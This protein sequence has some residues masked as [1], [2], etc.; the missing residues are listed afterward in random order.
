MGRPE[1]NMKLLHKFHVHIDQKK[2]NLRIYE[3]RE[4]NVYMMTIGDYAILMCETTQIDK[5]EDGFYAIEYDENKFIEVKLPNK[6]EVLFHF[7]TLIRSKTDYASGDESDNTE[8][9]MSDAGSEISNFSMDSRL[10]LTSTRSSRRTSKTSKRL[11]MSRL[12]SRSMMSI[13]EDKE[14]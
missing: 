4:Q 2:Y 9:Y 8:A 3:Q 6:P 13:Q 10:S 12:A 14:L 7:E 11:G 5:I 1:L